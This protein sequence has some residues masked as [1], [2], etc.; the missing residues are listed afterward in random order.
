MKSQICSAFPYVRAFIVRSPCV[1]RALTVD[2][3]FVLIVHKALTV[4]AHCVRS[5][6][7]SAPLRSCPPFTNRLPCIHC[8]FTVRSYCAQRSFSFY[9]PFSPFSFIFIRNSKV[10]GS[11]FASHSKMRKDRVSK[12]W[13][14]L[15]HQQHH[16]NKN[17]ILH[18]IIESTLSR[19]SP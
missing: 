4:S 1:H 18:V 9:F 13:M 2:S 10:K 17:I 8:A 11:V 7:L 5:V 15:T 12:G 14:K 6:A 16:F 19:A 3:H